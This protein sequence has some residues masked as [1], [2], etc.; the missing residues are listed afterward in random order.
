MPAWPILVWY[1][2]RGFYAAVTE[3]AHCSRQSAQAI[4]LSSMLTTTLLFLPLASQL[5]AIAQLVHREPPR[6]YVEA[7]SALAEKSGKWPIFAAL[8][9]QELAA[10]SVADSEVGAIGQIPLSRTVY[11]MSGLNTRTL[12]LRRQDAAAYL[13]ST[14]PDIIWYRRIDFY[15]GTQLSEDPRFSQRYLFDGQRGIAVRRGSPCEAVME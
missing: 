5:A 6:S 11:D 8:L 15:W 14:S 4:A 9:R 1:A 7:V 10:C 2:I 13:S 12:A 3:L